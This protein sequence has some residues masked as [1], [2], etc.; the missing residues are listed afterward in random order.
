MPPA[1]GYSVQSPSR[2][3]GSRRRSCNQFYHSGESP[4]MVLWIFE[5]ILVRAT[6]PLGSRWCNG[7]PAPGLLAYLPRVGRAAFT[8]SV[9]RLA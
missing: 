2:S 6:S 7:R 5:P 8:L 4:S 3:I 1:H 9:I